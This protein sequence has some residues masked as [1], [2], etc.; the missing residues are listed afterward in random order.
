[1]SISEGLERFVDDCPSINDDMFA[2]QIGKQ[3]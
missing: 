1:M 3:T 2:D